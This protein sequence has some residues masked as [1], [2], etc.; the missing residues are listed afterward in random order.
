MLILTYNS[1]Q[2]DKMAQDQ[3]A[4][5]VRNEDALGQINHLVENINN[6][7]RNEYHLNAANFEELNDMAL[8][9]RAIR[10]Y[11]EYGNH[12]FFRVQNYIT[13][14]M[15]ENGMTWTLGQMQDMTQELCLAL[16]RYCEFRE[17]NYP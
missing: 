8:V 17:H 12:S 4:I 16:L 5:S 2:T 13:G 7:V 15:E 3:R 14:W 9:D 10:E 11:E 1:Y 6:T